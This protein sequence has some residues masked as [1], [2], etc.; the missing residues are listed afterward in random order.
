MTTGWKSPQATLGLAVV[1]ALVVGV[2]L[3]HWKWPRVE[4]VAV[5]SY[6]RACEFVERP[7]IADNGTA[8]SSGTS[9]RKVPGMPM[10]YLEPNGWSSGVM[11]DEW[12]QEIVS[13]GRFY[14]RSDQQQFGVIDIAPISNAIY[15][16]TA[17]A[18]G[19]A[20][21]MAVVQALARMY[22]NSVGAKSVSCA[23][24][25]WTGPNLPGDLVR[26]T[27]TDTQNVSSTAV[28]AVVGNDPKARVLIFTRGNADAPTDEGVVTQIGRSMRQ[29]NQPA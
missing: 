21:N 29:V 14:P 2:V 9:P 28:L 18:R 1:G 7:Y 19:T 5:D 16:M 8:A 10:Q 12:P 20:S 26:L 25:Y 24:K 22:I 13:N 27:I 11:S 6:G 3:G 4:T 15:S 17:L 23:P